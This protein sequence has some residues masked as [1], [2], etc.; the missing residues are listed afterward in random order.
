MKDADPVQGGDARNM[1]D[2]E[3]LTYV[4]LDRRLIDTDL[5]TS[6]ERTWID[7]Y[8]SDT[9]EKIGPRVDGLALAWLT[10]ACA[11]L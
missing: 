3:T 9:L 2:F 11:P 7:G 5:L 6:D 4:P 1:L 10:T 8:H